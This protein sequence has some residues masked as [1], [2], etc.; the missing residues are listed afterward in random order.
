METTPRKGQLMTR[1][2]IMSALKG[3]ATA[4]LLVWGY[5]FIIKS[6]GVMGYF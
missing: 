5:W 2:E 4:A 3:A 1:G 6:L